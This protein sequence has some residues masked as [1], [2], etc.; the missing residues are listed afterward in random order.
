M[1]ASDSSLPGHLLQL[2]YLRRGPSL[3]QSDGGPYDRS[4]QL[5]LLP[6]QQ[7]PGRRMERP[8]SAV[9]DTGH[10]HRHVSWEVYIPPPALW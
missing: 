8:E 6:F 7:V 10:H 9:L 5:L 3:S 4:G 1:V 2:P